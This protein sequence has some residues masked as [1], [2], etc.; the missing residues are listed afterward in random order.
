MSTAQFGAVYLG[1]SS[2]AYSLKSLSYSA[3]FFSMVIFTRE[4]KVQLSVMFKFLII[5][6]TYLN[7]KIFIKATLESIKNY[8]FPCINGNKTKIM[9]I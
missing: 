6:K 1:T 3:D 8:V 2:T 7:T 4:V 5:T 9:K